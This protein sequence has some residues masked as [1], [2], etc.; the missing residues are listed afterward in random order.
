MNSTFA[1][2]TARSLAR[3]DW[4]WKI[5]DALEHIFTRYFGNNSDFNYAVPPLNLSNDNISPFASPRNYDLVSRVRHYDESAMLRFLLSSSSS[6]DEKSTPRN[7]SGTVSSDQLRRLSSDSSGG[8]LSLRGSPLSSLENME[9]S[10]R[11]RSEL[12]SSAVKIEEDVLVMDAIPVRSLARSS[13]GSRSGKM[14]SPL[15]MSSGSG[16]LTPSSPVTGYSKREICRSWEDFGA[17][18]YG[19][20]CVFAHGK[21]EIDPRIICKTKSEMAHSKEEI[22][23][24]IISKAKSEF[25]Q[26][27]EEI[28]PRIISKSKSEV[29]MSNSPKTPSKAPADQKDR[30]IYFLSL[31]Q[32]YKNRENV[33]SIKVQDWLPIDDGIRVALPYPAKYPPSPEAVEGYM[34]RKLYGPRPTRRKRLPVFEAIC[35]CDFQ[36]SP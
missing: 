24:N 23:P 6:S 3:G 31:N 7:R 19:P 1:P 16:L 29:N 20:K 32:Q 22:H 10:P 12:A 28:D 27:K 2:T 25:A 5:I 18:K 21:E 11:R 30:D 17:C 13:G 9:I 14:K 34:N 4:R 26:C 15:S 33:P 35:P 8:C 36:S